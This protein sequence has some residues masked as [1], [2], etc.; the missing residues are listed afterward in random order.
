MKYTQCSKL[1]QKCM[2]VSSMVLQL[3]NPPACRRQHRRFGFNPWVR[4]IP[5]RKKWQPTPVILPRE[6]HGQRNLGT[7]AAYSP[8]GHKESDKTKPVCR[9][10]D[11]S[12]SP[13]RQ[14]HKE[15]ILTV[16]N[17]A[18]FGD[19][20]CKLCIIHRDFQEKRRKI[21]TL[22]RKELSPFLVSFKDIEEKISGISSFWLTVALKSLYVSESFYLLHLF[23]KTRIEILS[24]RGIESEN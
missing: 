14:R 10:L 3:K 15:T 21:T 20:F 6:S 2:R 16:Q 9:C 13:K 24:A 11:V 22:L 8:K 7:E 23:L 18:L 12:M 19:W 5:W 4:K 17:T 1:L